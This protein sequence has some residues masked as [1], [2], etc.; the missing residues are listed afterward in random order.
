M[1]FQ[2]ELG[3]RQITQTSILALELS[4]RLLNMNTKSQ[5]DFDRFHQLHMLDQ[6]EEDNDLS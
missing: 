1:M 4:L 3:L 5:V 6:T 2:T